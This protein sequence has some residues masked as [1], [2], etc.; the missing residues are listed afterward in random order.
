MIRCL[1]VLCFL[2]ALPAF[3]TP[4]TVQHQGRLLDA[5]GDPVEGL[6][7]L[8]FRLYDAA[9]AGTLLW[10]EVHEADFENGFYTVALGAVD[11]SLS[12]WFTGD[13]PLYLELTVDGGDPLLPRQSIA[14]VPFAT[15]AARVEGGDVDASEIRLAGEVVVDESGEW[16]GPTPAMSWS[17]LSDVPEDLLDGDDDTVLTE[18]EVEAMVSDDGFVMESS[19]AT[20]ATS[21]SYSDLSGTPSLATVATSGSFNDL[22]NVPSGLQDGDDDT[23]LTE[24]EV[25]AM[26]LDEAVD[27]VPEARSMARSWSLW[28]AQAISA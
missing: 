7:A 9:E 22:S 6:Y 23:Q 11:A 1:A 3:A 28:T 14:S 12:E 8:E 13:Q 17:D 26:V 24:T 15:T 27:L 25:E 16:V 4:Q 2:W 20:V 18:A 5:E 21:G 10:E 19:L